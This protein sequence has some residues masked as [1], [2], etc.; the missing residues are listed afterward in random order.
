MKN[1]LFLLFIIPGLLSSEIHQTPDRIYDVI[2]S[3]INIQ[4]DL[5]AEK[6][7]GKV[8][9][10]I[11]LLKT[12]LNEIYFHASDI[13]ILGVNLEGKGK[14]KF[15]TEDAKV[16]ISLEKAPSLNQ[17][18]DITLTYE[19]YPTRGVYFI[20]PDSA[21][22][23][24]HSQAWTQ[25][26]DE[27]NQYWVPLYD[28]PNDKY[29]FEVF[30]NVKKPYTGI[31]NGKLI[32]V[33]EN[34]NSRTYHWSQKEPM[35]PYLIS[36]VVGEFQKY[37]QNTVDVPVGYWVYPEHSKEDAYRSFG[38]T[39]EMITYFNSLTGIDYPY[40]KYDQVII[41]D[42]MWG[43]ME[44][45]TLTHQTDRTMHTE[46]ARPDHT[47]DGLVAHEL[48]HQWYGDMLTTRNWANIWLNEGF[49]TFLTYIWLEH[50]L[51]IDE[52]EYDRMDMIQDVRKL[53]AKKRRPTVDFNYVYSMELF[54]GNVYAKGAI[55]LNMLRSYLG[56]EE[57][58]RSIQ[59]Y[60]KENMYKNVETTDLKK[61]FEEITGQNLYW[62][63]DQWIYTA[64][65]P[66]YTVSYEYKRWSKELVIHVSQTQDIPSSSI[67]KMPVNLLIDSGKLLRKQVW[68]E[69]QDTSFVIPLK[70]KPKMV[71]FDEGF[72]ILKYLDFE[73]SEKD[74]IYQAINAPHLLDRF[75]AIEEL[76]KLEKNKNAS[77][78]LENII[79]GYDFWGMKVEAVKAFG[80]LKLKNSDQL[81]RN[82]YQNQKDSRVKGAIVENLDDQ[83]S[84]D[85]LEEIIF[86]ETNDFVKSDAV[87]SLIKVDYSKAL[88]LI[89][90]IMTI[91]SHNNRVRKSAI[92]VYTQEKNEEN[93]NILKNLALYG[94]IPYDVRSSVF[95]GLYS[96]YDDYPE[97]KD[98][99]ISHLED[100]SRSVR[101]TCISILSSKGDDSAI[102]HL[103]NLMGKEKVFIEECNS[104]IK[105]IKGRSDDSSKNGTDSELD[106]LKKKIKRIKEIIGS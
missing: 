34:S 4:V 78:T 77:N 32:N 71:V 19:A 56:E 55:V 28:H 57:F 96:Y 60:T 67:F 18:L 101:G 9:H 12:D 85:F 58:W 100:P 45:I 25:G 36:F 27:D 51:G 104:A 90:T 7:S 84:S 41:E 64:G 35:S 39:P 31:S 21:Y 99:I 65:I 11:K 30:L 76:G 1:Y 75:W 61:T 43:G 81:L 73:K 23:E 66:E 26:E 24:K 63:F 38:K 68:V 53:D 54:N 42:F 37:D 33:S 87:E 97:V 6:I 72:T 13:N 106:R 91:D 10:S 14:L 82:A 2:H 3:K 40:A 79:N 16:I 50:D 47:S 102:P 44:N 103:K 29:S 86:N 46:N 22:P 94:T 5:D 69:T 80:K 49:A 105:K 89:D 95:W 15:K 74:L 48:A 59:H 52:A 62:F 83:E 93:L 92:K 70:N 8:T 98:I 17:K 20:K 88:S